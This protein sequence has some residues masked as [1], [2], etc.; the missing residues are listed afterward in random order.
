MLLF[1]S[2]LPVASG[3]LSGRSITAIRKRKFAAAMPSRRPHVVPRASQSG[4]N[5]SP[6]PSSDSSSGQ[7][8]DSFNWQDELRLLFD[9]TLNSS[10]RQVLLQDLAKRFPDAVDDMTKSS[11]LKRTGR[12]LT[13]VLR[14]LTDDVLPDLAANGPRYVSR[15]MESVTSGSSSSSTSSP[16]A[17]SFKPPSFNI[18]DVRREFRNVFNRTP[19]GLFTPEFRVMLSADGY[20]IRQYPT[21]IIAETTMRPEVTT[22][23]SMTEVES[24]VA[25]GRSFNNLAGYLFGKNAENK[26]MKMTTPVMLDKGVPQKETM[27]FIIGEYQ[28]LD[29]VP[30]TL[31]NS[32]TLRE[33]PGK[34]YAVVEF[35]GYVTQGEAKR[36]KAKLLSLLSR[37]NIQVSEQGKTSYKC[38]IYNGPSTLPNLRRNELM[39]EVSYDSE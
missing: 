11:C 25:M 26:E 28:S 5:S 19:E 30:K 24:A 31:G 35:S 23:A 27:S 39:I 17:G 1:V 21:L 18:E 32:V 33:E 16:A 36:Q 10:A 37:D 34:I 38:M 14:Q 9:P 20:Q 15:A 7:E 4:S 2:A 29:D 8:R 6:R 12:G 13:D 22:K 3:S